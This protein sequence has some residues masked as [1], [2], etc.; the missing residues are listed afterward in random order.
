MIITN[1]IH[2]F[3]LVI[4]AQCLPLVANN[5]NIKTHP[6]TLTG[7]S[8]QLADLQV[9]DVSC[10]NPLA[11]SC[12]DLQ[13]RVSAA[14]GFQRWTWPSSSNWGTGSASLRRSSSTTWTS[15]CPR[16]TSVSET[17]RDVSCL[18]CWFFSSS[19]FT[20][21]PFPVLLSASSAT[22]GSISSM[23]V[24]VDLLDQMELVDVSDQ[25]TLDVFFSSGGDEGLLTSPG[26]R[27]EELLLAYRLLGRWGP[28]ATAFCSKDSN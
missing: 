13:R 18:T 11:P 21:A 3:S 22:I 9:R 27:Q 2:S 16:R 12:V 24:N 1:Q 15:T 10:I 14:K 8:F 7:C 5:H 25:E 6:L 28:R 17:T 23:E 26:T 20:F 4:V 19:S